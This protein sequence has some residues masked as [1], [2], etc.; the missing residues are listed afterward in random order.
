M[1]R[2]IVAHVLVFEGEFEA[3]TVGELAYVFSVD[4][5]PGGLVGEFGLFPV[6]AAQ[7]EF[8]I[9]YEHVGGAGV[10][11]NAHL[12]AGFEKGEATAY[13]GFW[14]GVENG[15]AGRGAALASIADARELGNTCF[16]EAVGREHIDD[17]GR[18]WITN[19]ATVAYKEH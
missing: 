4:F 7:G 15:W 16:Y 19:G 18:T 3:G 13:C 1:A 11:V 9:A 10:E 17:F 8:T 5:L 12:I 14:G 2:G 6:F